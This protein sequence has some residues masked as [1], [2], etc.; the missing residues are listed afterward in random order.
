MGLR[1]EMRRI[2]EA[3]RQTRAQRERMRMAAFL[4]VRMDLELKGCTTARYLSTDMN[5]RV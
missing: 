1:V 5:T 3:A 4:A 2:G